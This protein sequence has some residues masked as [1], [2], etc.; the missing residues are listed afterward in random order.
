MHGIE[1]LLKSVLGKEQI[2]D[3][4]LSE[5]QSLARQ[6]PYFAPLHLLLAEKIKTL[7]ESLYEQQ[8]EKA[9]LYVQQPLWLHYLLNREKF[10]IEIIGN[11]ILNESEDRFEIPGAPIF[12]ETETELVE[13]NDEP[14]EF[15]KE[16]T[17]NV[18]NDTEN[19]IQNEAIE[20]AVLPSEDETI[21]ETHETQ[22][23]PAEENELYKRDIP[24][25]ENTDSE[26][27]NAVQN[28]PEMDV[29]NNIS[30]PLSKE[31]G[32]KNADHHFIP[33]A[34][35]YDE[36]EQEDGEL[37]PF[38][39]P[40]LKIEPLKETGNDILFEPYHTVDYF[41]SQGIKDQVEE[42]PKDR[43][44]HQLKSFTEWLKTMKKLPDDA[45]ELQM[46]TSS[47]EKVQSLA[48]HSIEENEV[49][50]E[51]MAEVWIKQGDLQKAAEVYRKLSLQNPS[52]SHYFAAK[53]ESLNT[54]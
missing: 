43:F 12:S 54:N 9:S 8:L 6:Y 53:I 1:S 23:H 45:R 51:T 11:E 27:V 28:E 41:A 4:G 24:Q 37:P 46:D 39:I 21:I 17:E 16:T 19:F 49:L 40:T 48:T 30:E 36:A 42:I 20:D 50:T 5:L 18:N 14:G 34:D 15:E 7:D 47:E 26:I 10:S 2:T 3:C 25:D 33:E 13:L 32:L 31:T 35:E 38:H 22:I 29:P 44:S 52:K